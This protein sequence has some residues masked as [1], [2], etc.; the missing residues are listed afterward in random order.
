MM[1]GVILAMS[2]AIGET[3][4]LVAIGAATYITF[5]PGRIGSL[6]EVVTRPDKL[7]QVPFDSFTTIPMQIYGWIN[8]A[9][10][11]FQHVAAAAILVLLA[12]LLI[13]NGLAI[14]IRQH[15]QKKIRW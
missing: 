3:A 15:F 8:E 12:I 7:A 2:R 11:D 5:T 14:Y 4:P 1:T 9:K 6:S 10:P 13:S